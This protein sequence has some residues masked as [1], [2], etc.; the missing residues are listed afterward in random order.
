[1][2]KFI[3]EVKAQIADLKSFAN[4]LKNMD[5]T[6]LEKDMAEI[7]KYRAKLNECIRTRKC[8]LVPFTQTTSGERT[9]MKGC[10][11]GQTGHHIIPDSFY[12]QGTVE[13]AKIIKDCPNY[14]TDQA[15]TVCPVT[16]N[17]KIMNFN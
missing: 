16:S 10:C 7:M 17:N 2:Y 14:K 15:A 9:T 12:H 4:S 13:E 6:D 1:M 8:Q 11:K 5:G 3:S